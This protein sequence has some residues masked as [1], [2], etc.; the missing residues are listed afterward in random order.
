[1]LVLFFVLVPR[2]PKRQGLRETSP[3]EASLAGLKA[4]PVRYPAC[5]RFSRTAGENLRNGIPFF[6]QLRVVLLHL[7]GS[8]VLR[9]LWDLGMPLSPHYL[10]RIRSPPYQN[11]NT[12]A[13]RDH[14]SGWEATKSIEPGNPGRLGAGNHF[15][16]ASR[17]AFFKAAWTWT[18]WDSAPSRAASASA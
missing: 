7:L 11:D 13:L 17:T 4:D 8:I 1:M 16:A 10:R 2:G 15:L 5:P 18:F 6:R 14:C 9:G 3:E 12:G